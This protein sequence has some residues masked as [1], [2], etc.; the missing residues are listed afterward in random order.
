LLSSR[1]TIHIAATV[2]EA[3]VFGE[4]RMGGAVERGNIAQ[5]EKSLANR[6]DQQG[7]VICFV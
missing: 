3:Q 1:G 7:G 4:L 5:A 6:V 2:V